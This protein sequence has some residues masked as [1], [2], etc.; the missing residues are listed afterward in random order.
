MIS[1]TTES[2]T[3]YVSENNAR[4]FIFLV[5]NIFLVYKIYIIDVTE[6][7]YLIVVT[8]YNNYTVILTISPLFRCV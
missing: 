4:I 8:F 3:G 5:K 2:I 6:K 7:Y 1:Q